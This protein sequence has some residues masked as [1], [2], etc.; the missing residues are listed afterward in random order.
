MSGYKRG[1]QYTNKKNVI[2]GLECCSSSKCVG[3]R[4]P[5]WH[6]VMA[7]AIKGCDCI[8]EL[9]RDVREMLKEQEPVKPRVS[10]AEQR[11]GKCNKI[12]EMDGWT[13]CPWCGKPIDW[14][15]WWS[16]NK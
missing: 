14:E 13:T 7:D 9:M 15:S 2:K 3:R 8:T 6:D 5:Y 16:E 12:I 4:C 1:M 11:C 10:S